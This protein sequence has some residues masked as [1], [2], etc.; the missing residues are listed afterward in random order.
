MQFNKYAH[1]H[2]RARARK[3]PHKSCRRDALLFRTHHHLFRKGVTL[4]GIQ[5][6][7]SRGPVSGHAYRSE[8]VTGSKEQEGANQI[9]DGIRVTGGNGGGKGGR[10]RERGRER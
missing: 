8:G 5:Q 6:L 10:G 2:T 1:T 3:K 4:A 9:G 7:R